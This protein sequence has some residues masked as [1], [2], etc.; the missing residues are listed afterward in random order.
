MAELNEMFESM[1]KP[2]LLNLYI[3][4]LFGLKHTFKIGL[5]TRTQE[6]K[7][8]FLVPIKME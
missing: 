7:P 5:M 3:L 2:L 6:H 8:W 1:A 4:L